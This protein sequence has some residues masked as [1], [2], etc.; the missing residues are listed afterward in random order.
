MKAFLAWHR[1]QFRKT[2]NLVELGEGCCRIDQNLEPLL[3]RAAPL[4]E[5]A[6]KFRYPGNPYDATAEEASVALKT[7]REG[8]DSVLGRL[9]PDIGV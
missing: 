8:F 4:T 9:P 5:Y 6:W 3:R 7:A 1:I 2:H